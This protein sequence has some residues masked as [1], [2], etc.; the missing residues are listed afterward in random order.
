MNDFQPRHLA[1]LTRMSRSKH[2]LRHLL[3]LIRYDTIY[4]RA[5]KS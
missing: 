5:L 2:C 4:L 3:P 1:C